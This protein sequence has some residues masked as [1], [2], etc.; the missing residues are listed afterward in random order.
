MGCVTKRCQ[1][2][3][4]VDYDP[5]RTTPGDIAMEL[6]NLLGLYIGVHD[7]ADHGD[8]TI[9]NFHPTAPPF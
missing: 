2:V 7:F 1:L 9:H 3:V 8:V 6:D 5:D 4:E